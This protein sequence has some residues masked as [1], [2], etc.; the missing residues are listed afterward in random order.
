MRSL[1][2]GADE[3][4]PSRASVSPVADA[5]ITPDPADHHHV[6]TATAYRQSATS[7]F[8]GPCPEPARRPRS[9]HPPRPTTGFNEELDYSGV[10]RPG[11]EEDGLAAE[12]QSIIRTPGEGAGLLAPVAGALVLLGWAG[13]I[14]YL[15]RLAKQF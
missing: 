11:S 7:A 1:R 9:R 3:P 15:N 14:I 5:S 2:D 6:D 13:H 4:V 10:P 12:G 8:R